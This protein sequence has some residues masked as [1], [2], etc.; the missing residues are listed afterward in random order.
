[1]NINKLNSD[2]AMH[3]GMAM[4]TIVARNHFARVIGIHVF[5]NH[6]DFPVGAKAF[7]IFK[8]VEVALNEGWVDLFF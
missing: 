2:A 7:G 6:I 3:N 1:M 8:A 4:V 5:R